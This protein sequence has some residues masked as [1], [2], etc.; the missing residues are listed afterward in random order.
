MRVDLFDFDLPEERIALRPAVPRESARLLAVA[1]DGSLADRTVGDLPSLLAAGRHPRLQRH[2]RD[3]GAARRSAPPAG[4]GRRRGDG[5]CRRDAASCGRRPSAGAPSL[6]PA[7]RVRAGDRLSF[8]HGGNACLAGM[9]EAD[10]EARGEAGEVDPA[11]RPLGP[12]LDE[13]IAAVGHIPLPPYIASRTAR[14][15]ARP[16]RLPDD[17]RPRGGR[18]GGADGRAALHAG[19]VGGA[20]GARR[21]PATTVTL[22]VGAGTFLPVKA[23]DTADHRMHA[24]IGHDRR[25]D[26]GAR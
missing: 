14:G 20:R 25:G 21:R 12:A 2:A 10:V 11:L 6:R 22:H 15:R 17:L 7:K 4:V 5:A 24:E 19:A 18:G 3:P 8:G 23:D 16:R 1:P 9:L 13:A 26:G